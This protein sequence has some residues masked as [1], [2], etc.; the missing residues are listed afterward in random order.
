MSSRHR[1]HPPQILLEPPKVFLISHDKSFT[2]APIALCNVQAY[3][4]N[5]HI[6]TELIYISEKKNI[7]K[8][9][10]K[11]R[12]SVVICNSVG[13]HQI[14]L[15]LA[16]LK[17]IKLYWYIHEWID[18][19]RKHYFDLFLD[20]RINYIFPSNQSHD[21][22]NKHVP[23]QQTQVIYNGYNIASL[24]AKRTAPLTNPCPDDATILIIVGSI[25]KFKNQQAFIDNVFY[26][27]KTRHPSLHLLLVGNLQISLTIKPE[28]ETCIHMTGEV[29]NAIAY[30]NMATIL[31][32]YSIDEVLAMNVMEALYCEKPVVAAQAGALTEIVTHAVNGYIHPP[33]DAQACFDY[34]DKLISDPSLRQRI[35]AAG[36]NSFVHDERIQYMPLL[37]IAN[38]ITS[39][40]NTT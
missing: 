32:S 28:Y 22:F 24:E 2:G 25:N 39:N 15:E 34:L 10:K 35:A 18:A 12:N 14:V 17:N 31:V 40:L 19:K 23:N 37:N 36:K 9:I 27:L 29:P 30:I 1:Q 3:L 38:I 16:N 20:K 11:F 13:T 5:H 7:P 21:S 26:N 8:Y 6:P 33:N 4:Q